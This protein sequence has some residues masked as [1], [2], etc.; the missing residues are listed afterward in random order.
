MLDTVDSRY[1][2]V[3]DIVQ[4]NDGDVAF[5]DRAY[6]LANRLHNGQLRKDGTPYIS[7]PV[8][9]AY[10]LAK[11]GFDE[12]VI[13]GALLHDV[14][15]DCGCSLETIKKEFNNTVAE[16]VDC[17]SAIDEAKFVFDDDDLYESRNFEK[18]SMEEQSFKKLVEIG[19]KN[20]LGFCIKFADRLHNLNTIDIFP[21]SK[22]LEKVKETE[23]W[24]IPIAKV[25]NAEY[26]YRELKNFCFKIIHIYDGKEYFK[27]YKTYHNLSKQYI[28]NLKM[29]FMELFASSNIKQVEIKDV[30][31]YKTFEDLTKLLKTTNISKV[32]QGQILKVTNYNIYFI[33]ENCKYEEALT[34]VWE[35]FNSRMNFKIKIIDAKIGSF[36]N[37]PYFQFEDKYK[38]KFNMYIMTK[39]EY[40]TQRL[41]TLNGQMNDMINNN[42]DNLGSDI[43]RVLTRSGEVKYMPK[44]ST[45]LDFAFKLHKELGFGFKYATINDSKSKGK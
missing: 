25:L 40:T 38:N 30:R 24:I 43:I 3:H 16:L 29:E 27:Q 18:A 28:E 34:Q 12:N 5:V 21:Y 9:V 26:F 39:G 23:R 44:N 31:E 11:L 32:S 8:E 36:T 17:V 45:V 15:E 20:P 41:G 22:Q 2:L 6:N 10:I 4:S 13:S 14:V 42:L 1:K 37:K 33:Y 19:K 35:V 7:H